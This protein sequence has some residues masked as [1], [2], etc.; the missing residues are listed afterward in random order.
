MKDLET[1]VA[2]PSI[3]E[4]K[5]AQEIH[6]QK[7]LIQS[8]LNTIKEMDYLLK[9]IG[10][11]KEISLL[12]GLASGIAT[13]A[14]SSF[15]GYLLDNEAGMFFGIL[16]GIP[17]AVFSGVATVCIGIEKL[18]ARCARRFS[19][20]IAADK[21]N[22]LR[23]PK[24][25]LADIEFT[26]AQ[27]DTTLVRG[28]YLLVHEKQFLLAQAT[29]ATKE[30][31][32]WVNGHLRGDVG[33]VY[34]KLKKGMSIPKEDVFNEVRSLYGTA[35][36]TEAGHI[37]TIGAFTKEGVELYADIGAKE[38]PI[39]IVSKEEPMYIARPVTF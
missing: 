5:I 36:I 16:V 29:N 32:V 38:H 3:S 37:G 31:L 28:E 17:L 22:A 25:E 12:S 33:T 27:I 39:H 20:Q 23:I 9:Y 21:E 14:V 34:T 4:V 8:N 11:E 35:V 7:A 2:V 26:L 6:P 19:I 1:S 24:A 10:L 18:E 13:V 30:G 15:L